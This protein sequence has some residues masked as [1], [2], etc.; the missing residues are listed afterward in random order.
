MAVAFW[1]GVNKGDFPMEVLNDKARRNLRQIL[2][3]KAVEGRAPGAINTKDHQATARK[4]AE[5]SFVLLKNDNN[6]LPLDISKI[7]S[8]AVVGENGAQ[9]QAYGGGSARIKTFYEITPLDGI[10]RYVGDRATVS[11]S[12]GY[13][14]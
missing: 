12:T 3:T 6:V 11:Y 14:D 2:E 10:L 9:L 1:E 7:K 4:V 5:E 8:I 13:T